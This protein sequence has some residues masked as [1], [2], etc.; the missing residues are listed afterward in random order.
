MPAAPGARPPSAP[1]LSSGRTPDVPEAA[2]SRRDVRPVPVRTG[3]NVMSVSRSRRCSA[4]LLASPVGRGTVPARGD[5]SDAGAG[6]PPP[7]MR[8]RGSQ[9][10]PV[11]ARLDSRRTGAT[12][13]LG[14]STRLNVKHEQHP[15]RHRDPPADGPLR[16][17]DRAAGTPGGE[18]R[19]PG[20]GRPAPRAR[21]GTTPYGGAGPRA[22]RSAPGRLAPEETETEAE[23]VCG[24]VTRRRRQA[25]SAGS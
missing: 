6:A 23:A 22:P 12:Q 25:R 18:V 21:P 19:Q 24:A 14:S 8:N 20:A 11:R 3:Q 5:D 4:V 7:R 13:D 2:R 9:R 1:I 10:R 15:D 17:L 16:A